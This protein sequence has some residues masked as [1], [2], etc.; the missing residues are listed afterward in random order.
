MTQNLELSTKITHNF[1]KKLSFALF[2]SR[3]SSYLKKMKLLFFKNDCFTLSYS[4]SSNIYN[5]IIVIITLRTIN[6]KFLKHNFFLIFSLPISFFMDT[7][8]THF[9]FSQNS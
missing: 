1:L 5:V 8:H 7:N 2:N 4:S 6:L 3:S 9:T